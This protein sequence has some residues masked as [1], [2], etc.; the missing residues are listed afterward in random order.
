LRCRVR[1]FTDG[2]VIGSREYVERYR[3]RDEQDRRRV[4]VLRELAGKRGERLCVMRG[5]QTGAV[6]GGEGTG[7][8]QE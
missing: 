2:L 1:Y 8:K 3:R 6:S 4:P 7:R 5:L